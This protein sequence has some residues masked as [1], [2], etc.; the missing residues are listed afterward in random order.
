MHTH[1]LNQKI[2]ICDIVETGVTITRGVFYKPL[3]IVFASI[4]N[5][6]GNV[7]FNSGENYFDGISFFLRYYD[8]P[9]KGMVVEY[10][11]GF[12]SI[13]NVTVIQR[14]SAL[15]IDCVNVA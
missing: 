8:V 6:K 14:N 7:R 9:K 5:Q 1:R 12:Y 3:L 11:K 10:N 15:I 13:Q 4:L 2:T